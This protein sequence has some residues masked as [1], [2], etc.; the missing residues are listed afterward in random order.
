MSQGLRV[1]V[2]EL[3]ASRI[4]TPRERRALKK[5]YSSVD[6]RVQWL[7]VIEAIKFRRY[8]QLTAAFCRSPTVSVFLMMRL[9]EQLSQRIGKAI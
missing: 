1:L 9:F 5:R 6:C 3:A 2:L 7:A 4:L 8:G